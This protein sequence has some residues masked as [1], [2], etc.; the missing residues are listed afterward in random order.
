MQEAAGVQDLYATECQRFGILVI[1]ATIPTDFYRGFQLPQFL[2]FAKQAHIG[3]AA[4]VSE[5]A[6]KQHNVIDNFERRLNGFHGC[7]RQEPHAYLYAMR[8]ALLCKFHKIA[9][10]FGVHN[11]ELWPQ[12]YEGFDMVKWF[13]IHNVQIGTHPARP[14]HIFDGGE[15]VGRKNAVRQINVYT[16]RIG[17]CL[18]NLTLV[19]LW[20]IGTDSGT[21]GDVHRR[22]LLTRKTSKPAYTTKQ[23]PMVTQSQPKASQ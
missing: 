7:F 10:G 6:R 19:Y 1:D 17:N 5:I 15:L 21:N 14:P 23:I 12:T 18:L 4:K 13:L 2:G 9:L 8:V 22:F 3:M 11:D 20:V 16:V